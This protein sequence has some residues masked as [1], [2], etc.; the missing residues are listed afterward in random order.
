MK[1]LAEGVIKQQAEAEEKAE[2]AMQAVQTAAGIA[3]KA[4]QTAANSLRDVEEAVKE[5]KKT[6][7][8]SAGV[9]ASVGFLLQG[10]QQLEGAASRDP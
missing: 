1:T 10:I 3:L 5:L 8:R 4:A 9:R 2:T 6:H 7:A